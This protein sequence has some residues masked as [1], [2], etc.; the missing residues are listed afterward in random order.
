MGPV[1]EGDHAALRAHIESVQDFDI[2]YLG[3]ELDAKKLITE[4]R[5]DGVAVLGPKGCGSYWTPAACRS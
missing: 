4:R 2:L 3:S 1:D 5:L